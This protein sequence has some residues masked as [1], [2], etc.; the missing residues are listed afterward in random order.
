M[1]EMSSMGRPTD[2]KTMTMVTKP[3]LG[4]LAAPIL[5]IV[6]VILSNIQIEIYQSHEFK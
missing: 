5:A 1:R 4:I 6:A 2:C 3:A